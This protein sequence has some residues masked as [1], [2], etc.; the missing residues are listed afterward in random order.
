[1]GF[2]GPTYTEVTF[3][4]DDKPTFSA[5]TEQDMGC[6]MLDN[7]AVAQRAYDD[8]NESIAAGKTPAAAADFNAVS[9][10]GRTFDVLAKAPK[11]VISEEPRRNAG[12][13]P[14]AP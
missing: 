4:K 6:M 12:R 3:L 2:A 9:L 8:L 1:M 14:K 7:A 5:E 10:R 11:L 13:G